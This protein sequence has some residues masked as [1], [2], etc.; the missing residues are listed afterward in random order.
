MRYGFV[1]DHRRCIGCHACTVACRIENQVPSGRFRTWVEYIERGEYADPR[2]YFLIH[3]CNHCDDAPCVTICPVR[4]LFRRTDGIVD[5]DGGLCIGCRAC[6]QACPYDALYVDPSSHTAEKC[7]FCTHR[8]DAGLQPAC[9]V[10]CPVEA[11]IAGDLDDPASKVSQLIAIEKTVVPRP[12]ARTRPK[13]HYIK[14]D[15]SA[16]APTA[17][18]MLVQGQ[19]EILV[20][21]EQAVA[22]AEARA[23]V[24][25]D[26]ARERPWVWK[27]SLGL[28]ARSI[29]AGSFLIAA[30]A[31]G[32]AVVRHH[33][34]FDVAAAQVSLVFLVAT[35]GVLIGDLGRPERFL[36]LLLRPQWKSWLAIGS[37]I[38]A[39]YAGVLV[40]WMLAPLTG[41]DAIETVVM[42]IGALAALMCAVYSAFLFRQAR[43]RVFWHSAL[44]PLHLFVQALIGGASALIL[45]AVVNS[46]ITG[47][48]LADDAFDVLRYELIGSLVAHGILVAGALVIQDENDDVDRARQLITRGTFRGPFSSV[49]AGGMLIPLITLATGLAEYTPIALGTSLL[50]LA[51]LFLWQHIWLQAGQLASQ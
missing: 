6:M 47:A 39:V 45:V 27:V 37:Y 32:L 49:I 28:W 31:T 2:R 5:F 8:V 30:L 46:W 44:T 11:I 23:N 29:A 15:E 48:W 12:E 38:I 22:E 40:L 19:M 17:E 18:A 25:S 43:R 21:N 16:P 35:A 1:I 34:L 51:G 3:R 14:A 4:A 13:L 41:I 24:R 42:C 7:H 26:T 36:S 10:V 9:V 50:T 33:W 20:Q